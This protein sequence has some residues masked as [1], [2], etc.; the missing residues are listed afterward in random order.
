MCTR[1]VSED[2]RWTEMKGTGSVFSFSVIW[3]SPLEAF[4]VPYV[5]GVVELDEGVKMLTNLVG[6]PSDSWCVG[7]PVRVEFQ[8]TSEQIHLPVFCSGE[9]SVQP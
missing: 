3:R 9:E 4:R 2:L 6:K 1:C 5:V 7:D 8:P